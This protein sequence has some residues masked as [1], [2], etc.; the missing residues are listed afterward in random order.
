PVR[1]RMQRAIE[2][3]HPDPKVNE[4]RFEL[5]YNAVLVGGTPQAPPQGPGRG[6]IEVL[7]REARLLDALDGVSDP[8]GEG[9]PSRVV[10][11]GEVILLAQPD[12][13]LLVKRIEETPWMPRVARDVVSLIDWVLASPRIEDRDVVTRASER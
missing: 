6:G 3:S 4:T 13:D 5:L 2:F 12:F 8:V 11:S 7:R 1:S 9:A 10:R